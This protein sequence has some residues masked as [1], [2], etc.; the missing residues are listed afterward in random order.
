[1]FGGV[2]MKDTQRGDRFAIPPTLFAVA[3]KLCISKLTC[4]LRIDATGKLIERPE[5]CDLFK[6]TLERR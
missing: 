4:D 5:R 2:T 3:C 6:A 1:M